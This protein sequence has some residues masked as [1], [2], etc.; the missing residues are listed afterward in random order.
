M[1]PDF[2]RELVVLLAFLF[3][4]I[5][6]AAI[7][8][9]NHKA[10]LSAVAEGGSAPRTLVDGESSSLQPRLNRRRKAIARDDAERASG[11][12]GQDDDAGEP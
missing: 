2:L 4:Y 8:L 12:P 10:D 9:R 3:I 1:D 6:L 5:V 11:R 7:L